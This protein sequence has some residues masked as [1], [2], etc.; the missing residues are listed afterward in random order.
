MSLVCSFT[1]ADAAHVEIAHVTTLTAT[2]ETASYD[3]A[4]ELRRA[5]CTQ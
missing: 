1:E 5:T 4:L 3:A 2:L